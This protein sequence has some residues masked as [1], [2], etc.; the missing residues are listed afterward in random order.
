LCPESMSEE[1]G[2][3]VDNKK[4]CHITAKEAWKI[5][6]K[7]LA[8]N[9]IL[10]HTLEDI[11]WFSREEILRNEAQKVYAWHIFVPKEW[12]IIKIL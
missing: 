6:T 11:P 1:Y 5:G 12:D 9:L 8:K 2:W 7:F 3:K 4:I 10:I